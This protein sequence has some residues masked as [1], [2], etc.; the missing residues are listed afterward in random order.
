MRKLD[1]WLD[2]FIK[3]TE[4]L[5]A[6][7]IF[8]F[9]TGVSTIASVLRRKAYYDMGYFPW[10]ANFYIILIAP[11]GVC[12]KSTVLREGTKLLRKLPDITLGPKTLT[13]QSL[14]PALG[15]AA[16]ER[17]LPGGETTA[18]SCISFSST[19]FGTLLKMN[20]EDLV[21]VLTDLWDGADE[22]FTKRTIGKGLEIAYNPWINIIAGTTPKWVAENIGES[23]IEMGFTSRCI[24]VY[25]DQK[26]RFVENPKEEIAKLG[27]AFKLLEADLIGD[28]KEISTL[29]GEFTRTGEARAWG[30]EWY[31]RLHSDIPARRALADFDGYLSRKQG[32][33]YKIAMVLNAAR[34]SSMVLE[35]ED[36]VRAAA[37][38]IQ[39]EKDM[40]KVFKKIGDSDNIKYTNEIQRYLELR[41]NGRIPQAELYKLFLLRFGMTKDDFLRLVDSMIAAGLIASKQRGDIVY[42]EGAANE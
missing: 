23:K 18:E 10:S 26:R 4:H 17:F 42:I 22:E 20:D 13:W 39:T 14:L 41:E 35:L 38:L 11:S 32:H 29:S 33:L 8:F 30:I 40:N 19:E 2:S 21:T 16:I 37:L 25:A 36:V 34:T 28:L 1:N 7:D 3:Y 9:W 27:P 12:T 15:E 31:E 6:P 24:P 5:E